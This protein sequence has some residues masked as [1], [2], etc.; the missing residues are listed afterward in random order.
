MTSKCPPPLLSKKA[1][2]T[3]LDMAVNDIKKAS[4]CSRSSVHLLVQA[5]E[6]LPFG[7]WNS[8]RSGHMG[9]DAERGNDQ[10]MVLSHAFS[11]DNTHV[12]V[13][14][15]RESNL[16][17][18][19]GCLKEAVPLCL[20]FSFGS[21]PLLQVVICFHTRLRATTCLKSWHVQLDR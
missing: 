4:L 13:R 7:E 19:L 1:W 20:L 11:D 3:L 16:I 21:Y 10:I 12:L 17:L 14:S 5:A 15:F 18:L 9:W 6:S 2:S 8:F